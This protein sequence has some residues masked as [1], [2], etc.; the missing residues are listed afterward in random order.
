M[1]LPYFTTAQSPGL[2]LAPPTSAATPS[3]TP[4]KGPASGS[5]NTGGGSTSATTAGAPEAALTT[6][7]PTTPTITPASSTPAPGT[8][9]TPSSGLIYG[10]TLPENPATPTITPNAAN[11]VL[12]APTTPTGQAAAQAAANAETANSGTS[13]SSSNS[14][15]TTLEN[16]IINELQN[17]DPYNTTSVENTYNYLSGQL[18]QQAQEA[19]AAAEEN[20]S[21]N[22]LYYSTIPEMQVSGIGGIQQNLGTGLGTLAANILNPI[23][24]TTSTNLANAINEAISFGTQA[25]AGQNQAFQQ[26]LEA[27]ELAQ[28]NEPTETGMF[29]GA[30]SA[31]EGTTNTSNYST[32]PYSALGSSL[33]G[34]G[35]NAEQ[36]AI[37]ALLGSALGAL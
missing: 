1:T 30:L 14:F 18:E 15:G 4:P 10:T 20:A 21:Q 6:A 32:N 12:G 11:G 27:A 9:G 22:G 3:I 19:T 37:E 7:T 17:P 5:V 34:S 29:G 16:T 8:S 36:Q 28:L 35:S 23:A 25:E 13:S 2:T 33:T 26:A 24:S 31:L